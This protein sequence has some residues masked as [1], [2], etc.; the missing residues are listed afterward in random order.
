M[1]WRVRSSRRAGGRPRQAR[2]RRRQ[3]RRHRDARASA[4]LP[5]PVNERVIM[6]TPW[7]ADCPCRR[8][9]AEKL[10][11]KRCARRGLGS[12]PSFAPPGAALEARQGAAGERIAA[13]SS[14]PRAAAR[15]PA[16]E[17]KYRGKKQ[18][19]QGT[20]RALTR[21]TRRPAPSPR[22]LEPTAAPLFAPRAGADGSRGLLA[23][24]IGAAVQRRRR[25]RRI[26]FAPRQ[27]RD[28]TPTQ[29]GAT[30]SG[31]CYRRSSPP[32]CRRRRRRRT[33][34]R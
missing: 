9:L 11:Q 8:A 20:N 27:R 5:L 1:L 4:P 16:Q 24:L 21:C 23:T 30:L 25:Q 3:G 12:V 14:P 19:C 32:R 28:H 6:R 33:S 29:H 7:V 17:A 31:G 18:L 15:A 10:L 13:V 22:A 2:S 26:F 34:T